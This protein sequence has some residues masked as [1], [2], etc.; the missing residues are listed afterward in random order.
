MA[1]VFRAEL[2]GAEGI[3]RELVVKK[4][5][6]T[7]TLDPEAVAMFVNE[8]RIAARMR[9]P[10]VVQVYEFG[11]T[12]DAYFLAM[13]L[14]EGCDLAAVIRACGT[15][16]VGAAVAGYVILELLDGCAY[17]HE[18]TDAKGVALGLVHRDIS[19]HNVLLSDAGE[20]KLAD[21][22]IAKAS[23][24][25]GHE[26]APQGVRGKFA[27]MPPE[28]ARGERLDAR[29]DLFAVGA[30]LYELLSGRK[31]YIPRADGD[32]IDAVRDGRIAPIA[33]V[34]PELPMALQAVVTRATAA[35]REARY[36]SARA[37]RADLSR[38][39]DACGLRPDEE[40]LRELVSRA[41]RTDLGAPTPRADR[42]L[43]VPE[44]PPPDPIE[45]TP[46]TDS[47]PPPDEAPVDAPRLSEPAPLPEASA[48]GDEGRLKV[49]R[50]LLDGLALLTF[51]LVLALVVQHRLASPNTP[52]AHA[53]R[54]APIAQKTVRIAIPD[55]A[56][57]AGWLSDERREGIARQCACVV[58]TV[59]YAREAELGVLLRERRVDVGLV[60]SMAVSALVSADL[61]R[62]LDRLMPEVDPQGYMNVR[63]GLR[64]E[65]A[66]VGR[67]TG[68]AGDGVYF[69]P[70]V[71][72][73]VT[74]AL[75]E[76]A[77]NAA[78]RDFGAQRE[79][80]DARLR[81][82]TGAGLPVGYALHSDPY[83]WTTWDLL[84]VA[85]V[86]GHT[87][88]APGRLWLS[89][90]SDRSAS[91]GW[92]ARTATAEPEELRAMTA[93]V[94]ARTM[95]SWD[96]AM[97]ALGVLHPTVGTERTAQSALADPSVAMAVAPV[98]AWAT[99]GEGARAMRLTRLP[100]GDSLEL[101][102][103]G[104]PSRVGVRVSTGEAIGWV[105]AREGVAA[106][107]AR[108]VVAALD[109]AS[110]RAMASRWPALGARAD[111]DREADAGAAFDALLEYASGALADGRF[112]VVTGPSSLEAV[113]RAQGR[114]AM[115][116]QR[117]SETV[118][119]RRNGRWDDALI[120]RLAREAF[121]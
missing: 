57:L 101:D 86:L 15:D 16:G 92:V 34:S 23:A 67:A 88:A 102:V 59:A 83:E 47:E 63:W 1:E 65:L 21:F 104:D 44:Q 114:P 107:S 25:V 39:L 105:V 85:F 75:R 121:E 53:Q 90:G 18:L 49:P 72:D 112:G 31:P 120:R 79:D 36:Q 56:R 42:T 40:G 117:A 45:V 9:H 89:A 96:V 77:V 24:L 32:L 68:R 19:P 87:G 110:V 108:A 50:R 28:Q 3:S 17:V 51:V 6:P 70:A 37:F 41:S 52:R 60:S 119:A 78:V 111:L 55:D 113:D 4:I 62:R 46:A 7:L 71:V 103:A 27:Y 69:L 35:D 82:L 61:V 81:A 14:V 95:L 118:F 13:E 93:G 100:R 84:S 20:V 26:T 116:W 66:N 10:N 58:Q 30:M 115:A 5:H 54:S 8:A 38:A 80:L 11:R 73:V 33:D 76:D 94:G 91:L 12:G 64:G 109:R 43:T 2:L 97:R 22:G 48:G 29:A 99:S 106:E 98:S 74:L